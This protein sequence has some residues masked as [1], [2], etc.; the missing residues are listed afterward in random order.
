[1]RIN[2]SWESRAHADDLV[3]KAVAAGGATCNALTGYGLMYQRDY[4]DLDGH[5]WGVIR[6][7]PRAVQES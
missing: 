3:A 1:M 4:Q 7:D 6:L 5:N 2:P